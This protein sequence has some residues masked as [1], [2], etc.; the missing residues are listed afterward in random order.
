MGIDFDVDR[1]RL[2]KLALETKG[3]ISNDCLTNKSLFVKAS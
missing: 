3:S 1:E 2:K